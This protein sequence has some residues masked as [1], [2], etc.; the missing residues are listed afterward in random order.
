LESLKERFSLDELGTDEDNIKV[1]L[2]NR[3]VGY[4]LD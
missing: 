1:A 3:V 4:A 2:K